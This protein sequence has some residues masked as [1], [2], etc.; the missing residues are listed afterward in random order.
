MFCRVHFVFSFQ[1]FFSSTVPFCLQRRSPRGH[2]LKSLASKS[3]ALENCP[4][5]GSRR[6]LFFKSLKFCRSPE[7]FFCRSCFLEITCKTFLKT[8]LFFLNRPKKNFEDLIIIIC[9]SE[10]LCP[11]PRIFLYPWPQALRPQL[12]LCQFKPNFEP[13]SPLSHINFHINFI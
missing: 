9:F 10:P 3:Q 8:L 7:K 4:V 12:H 13:L 11:W 6:A 2:I 1:L 5:L